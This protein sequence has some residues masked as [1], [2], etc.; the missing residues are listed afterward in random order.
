MHY[1]SITPAATTNLAVVVSD[2]LTLLAG[3]S[4]SLD[5]VIESD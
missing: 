3:G 2:W 1:I 4:V 5:A